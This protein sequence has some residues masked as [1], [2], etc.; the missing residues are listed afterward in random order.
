MLLYYSLKPP[1]ALLNDPVEP[2]TNPFLFAFVDY[3]YFLIRLNS[4]LL[5]D[6]R[7]LCRV[8][9]PAIFSFDDSDACYD[10]RMV[11]APLAPPWNFLILN[12]VPFWLCIELGP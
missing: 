11:E 9:A 3:A 6:S 8:A 4:L 12:L 2:S 7:F 5:F 1:F 10:P